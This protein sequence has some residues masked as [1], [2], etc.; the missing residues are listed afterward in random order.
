MRIFIIILI[1]T[2]TA[3]SH[4]SEQVPLPS[5]PLVQA[6]IEEENFPEL[7]IITIPKL[8]ACPVN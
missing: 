6:T 8:L 2:L 4:Q 7:K 5:V 1:T 3:C